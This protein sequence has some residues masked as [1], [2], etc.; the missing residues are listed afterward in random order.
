MGIFWDGGVLW[1]YNERI[2]SKVHLEDGI[3]SKN[4]RLSAQGSTKAA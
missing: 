1:Y 2:M 3:L 4:D